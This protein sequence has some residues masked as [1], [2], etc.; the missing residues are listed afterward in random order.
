MAK[1][2]GGTRGAKTSRSSGGTAGEFGF[3]K[4]GEITS[5]KSPFGAG[6]I[7]ESTAKMT[8][9]GLVSETQKYLD[10]GRWNGWGS[11]AGEDIAKTVQRDL[12]QRGVLV[13][14]YKDILELPLEGKIKISLSKKD[15]RWYAK[16]TMARN[17][18][19]QGGMKGALARASNLKPKVM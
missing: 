8:V 17:E 2:S 11:K 16:E 14:R 10:T 5:R 12:Y 6:Y 15:G 3:K 7:E 18:P 9:G 13:N 4:L 19:R 1:G